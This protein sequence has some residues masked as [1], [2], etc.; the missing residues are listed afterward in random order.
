MSVELLRVRATSATQG[1]ADYQLY[2]PPAGFAFFPDTSGQ[3]LNYLAFDPVTG[4]WEFGAGASEQ[5][6]LRRSSI[7]ASSAAGAPVDWPAGLREIVF[8]PLPG[9]ASVRVIENEQSPTAIGLADMGR[10]ILNLYASEIQLPLAGFAANSAPLG[11]TVEIINAAAAPLTIR[12]AGT[13]LIDNRTAVVVLARDDSARFIR[14][15]YPAPEGWRSERRSR[16][17]LAQL[18]SAATMT[19]AAAPGRMIEITGSATINE[20]GLAEEGDR[21]NLNFT[22]N[23]RLVH[24]VGGLPDRIRLPGNRDFIAAVGDRMTLA[25]RGGLW[26]CESIQRVVGPETIGNLIDNGDMRIDQR[27]AGI[28]VGGGIDIPTGNALAASVFP[29]DRWLLTYSGGSPATLIAGRVTGAPTATGFSTALEFTS[30]T[31]VAEPTAGHHF[32]GLQ[33]IE[34]TRLAPLRW[35][36]ADARPA[37][38]SF[39]AKCSVPGTYC[40]SVR[41]AAQ[42]RSFVATVSLG[43]SW[44]LFSILIPGET[45]SGVW[46]TDHQLAATV[47]FDLGS[48]ASFET[49]TANVWIAGNYHR[50]AGASRLNSTAPGPR[51][52]TI[53]GV[54]LTPVQ[55]AGPFPVLPFVRSLRDCQRYFEKSYDYGV[56]P[57]TIDSAGAIA[58]IAS[59]SAVYLNVRFTVQKRASPAIVIYNPS[60]GA[61][62]VVGASGTGANTTI[63]S[64]WPGT[65]GFNATGYATDGVG[66]FLHYTSNAEPVA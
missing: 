17:G 63:Y 64:S 1:L 14:A 16:V 36:T 50:A 2:A 24:S 60:T 62:G 18:A 29:V 34:G 65:T 30:P 21:F 56:R 19:L 27:N 32:L 26:T 51:I 20:F 3:P 58:G 35:G 38:L 25:R 9:F 4:A 46:P 45:T 42:S 31:G 12:P 15:A 6:I 10:V 13:N 39:W 55:E 52:I 28:G 54:M 7:V 66:Y 53:T 40:V 49:N 33:G 5:F 47:A 37:V 22:G 59:G 61:S 41:N 48:G 57:G 8:F 43:T 23:A 44:Q 11:F